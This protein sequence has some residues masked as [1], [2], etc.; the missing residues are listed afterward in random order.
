MNHYVQTYGKQLIK[1]LM[2]NMIINNGIS[3]ERARE[4]LIK[5]GLISKRTK[6]IYAHCS[7]WVSP[8]Q[9][10]FYT[11]D[12]NNGRGQNVLHFSFQESDI[13]QLLE[14]INNETDRSDE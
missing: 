8:K 3:D 11:L 6:F 1:E 5:Y 13:P 2:D 10:T 9:N 7:K 14:D 4:L 12:V